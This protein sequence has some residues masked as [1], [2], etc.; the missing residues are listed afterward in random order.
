MVLGG[1]GVFGGRLCHNLC[2]DWEVVVAGRSLALAR[3]FC[4]GTS[5]IPAMLDRDDPGF[6]AAL[7]ALRPFAVVDAAGPF[8]GYGDHGVARAALAAGA[9]YLDLSDDAGFTS[10]IGGLDA[11][12]KAVGLAALS[13]VSS[14]PALSSAVVQTLRAGIADIHLIDSAILPGNRA[15]RGLSVI[16]AILVQVGRPVIQWR[17]GR[18]DPQPGWSGLRRIA[19]GPLKGRSAAIIGAP[20]LALFPEWFAAR[21]VVF[22][23]GLELPVM[24]AGLWLLGWL[25]RLR[26]VRSLTPLARPL[27]FAANL[28]HRFGSDQGGMTVTVAGTTEDGRAIR[29]DWVLLAKGGDGPQV[30]AIPA[31]VMLI[32]L[33]AEQVAPGARACLA[34]FPLAD[35]VAAMD[36]LAITTQRCESPFPLIFAEAMAADFA[37][38]PPALCDLH[39]VIDLRHFRGEARIDRGRGLLARIVARIMGFPP[40]AENVPVQVT[41]ERRGDS[42]RWTRDFGE[43]RFHSTLS[44]GPKGLRERF[45][46]LDFDIGLRLQDGA[47]HY[48]V[49]AGRLFGLLPMPRWLLPVSETIEAVDPHGRATFDVAL[50]HPL[51][52]QIIRYRGWLKPIP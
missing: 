30:P 28:L 45:G 12:A 26:L 34:E 13:G 41:M 11:M 51:C 7:A 20:D 4:A 6:G 3:A 42:E 44:L 35:A 27:Q 17:G 22:R 10:G 50:S 29:R 46:A 2:A 47:L 14:V 38:L 48:P 52:G 24:Q 15:P 16:R 25:V 19:D 5:G 18:V 37:R 21:S 36:G 31:R 33:A 43:R 23:A 40:A 1:Y 32:R 8:Q 9:H 39:S 49:T